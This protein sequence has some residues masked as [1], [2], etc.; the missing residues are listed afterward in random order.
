MNK[1]NKKRIVTIAKNEYFTTI[2]RKEFILIVIAFPLFMLGMMAIGGLFA[3]SFVDSDE[4]TY[5][6]IDNSKLFADDDINPKTTNNESKQL[7]FKLYETAEAAKN[8]LLNENIEAYAVV[9]WDYVQSKNLTIYSL[10]GG[11]SSH[12]VASKLES[13]TRDKL[14]KDA[15]VSATTINFIKNKGNSKVVVLNKKGEVKGEKDDFRIFVSFISLFIFP[16]LFVMAIFV[17]A[18]YLLQGIVEEKESRIIEI[19]LSSATET[20]LFAGKLL[21]LGALGLTQIMIWGIFA[22]PLIITSAFILSFSVLSLILILIYFILGYLL[23]GSLFLAVGAISTS[24][25]E[26]NQ[27]SGLFTMI[28][29]FPIFFI[30]ILMENPNAIVFK[31]LSLFPPLTPVMMMFRIDSVSMYEVVLSI[32]LLAVSVVAVIKISARLFKTGTLMDR[33][34]SVREIIRIIKD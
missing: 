24:L 26:A 1:M 11:L 34:P 32:I 25:N 23:Y 33:R 17:S 27:I 5:G 28:V 8:D 31:I 21:G 20:E 4:K 13:I 15:N 10:K 9:P 19:L 16:F 18:S 12:A 30:G 14:L 2:K 7:K 3:M 29:M 6:I 22:L